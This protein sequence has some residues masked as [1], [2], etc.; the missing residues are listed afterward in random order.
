MAGGGGQQIV[1][2]V[3]VGAVAQYF[4]GTPG[5]AF[6]LSGLSIFKAVRKKLAVAMGQA[7]ILPLF[8]VVI[9]V[10]LRRW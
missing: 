5:G 10:V 6:G 3:T 9:K 4:T 2:V 8:C 1:T 7:S